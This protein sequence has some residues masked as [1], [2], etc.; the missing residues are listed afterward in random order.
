[1]NFIKFL[2]LFTLLFGS[3]LEKDSFGS[4][5][6]STK[7]STIASQQSDVGNNCASHSNNCDSSDTE[8]HVC[9]SFHCGYVATSFVSVKFIETVNTSLLMDL[10]PYYYNYSSILL[11]PPIS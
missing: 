4:V 2:L 6:S 10:T 1:M 5:S 9:H 11:R 8:C 3:F 7:N